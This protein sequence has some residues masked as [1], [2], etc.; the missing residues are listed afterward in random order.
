MYLQAFS[1]LSTSTLR[2][3]IFQSN[4]FGF[5][6]YQRQNLF[7]FNSGETLQPFMVYNVT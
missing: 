1:N 2:V 5:I 3:L 6:S 7:S 4:I